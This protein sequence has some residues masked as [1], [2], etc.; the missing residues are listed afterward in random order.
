MASD[1]MKHGQKLRSLPIMLLIAI[2]LLTAPISCQYFITADDSYCLAI[3][4]NSATDHEQVF[5]CDASSSSNCINWGLEEHFNRQTQ[6]IYHGKLF[7]N[8]I[9]GSA[10]MQ[11]T[12]LNERMYVDD[13]A[14][15]F[16]KSESE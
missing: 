7:V 10:I 11:E 2:S 5:W 6:G 9:G 16:I 8:G 1:A 14:F 12:Y 3:G 13:T 15:S 4:T